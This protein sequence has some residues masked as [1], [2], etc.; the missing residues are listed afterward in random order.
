ML[1][2]LRLKKS[3]GTD[4]R[5]RRVRV[6]ETWEVVEYGEQILSEASH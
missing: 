1:I 2:L 6:E 3:T 5:Y 4:E